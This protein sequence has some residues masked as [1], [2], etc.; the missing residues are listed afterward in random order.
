MG[1]PFNPLQYAAE[2]F[3]KA[4]S[5]QFWEYWRGRGFGP[6]ELDLY[7]VGYSPRWPVLTSLQRLVDPMVQCRLVYSQGEQLVPYAPH[8]TAFPVW[9]AKG[10][11]VGFVFR[12]FEVEGKRY[13]VLP[14]SKHRI[15]YAPGRVLTPPF[16]GLPND[17][18]ARRVVL[19]EGP[20]DM[21]RAKQATLPPTVASLGQI[22]ERHFFDLLQGRHLY[23]MTDWD[24]GGLRVAYYLTAKFLSW[25]KQTRNPGNLTVIHSPDH[26]GQD[27]GDLTPSELRKVFHGCQFT[28]LTFLDEV[29]RKG[30]DPSDPWQQRLYR[31]QVLGKT[32][33]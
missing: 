10:Q 16:L 27:P 12:S 15:P 31:T 5:A 2:T 30:L 14:S 1:D 23:L 20:V 28:P 8:A 18:T 32:E 9:D 13:Y 33:P 19:V 4:R 11:A 22:D 17:L 25:K 29:V 24:I 3:V 26:W 6:Q 21:L 7:S